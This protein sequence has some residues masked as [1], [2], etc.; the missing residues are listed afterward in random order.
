MCWPFTVI[1]NSSSD[2][3]NFVKSWTSASNFKS[4]SRS[5]Y[6]NFS[7]SRSEKIWKRSTYYHLF[8]VSEPFRYKNKQIK[9][10]EGLLSIE[11]ARLPFDIGFESLK[12]FNVLSEYNYSSTG[13]RLTTCFHQFSQFFSPIVLSWKRKQISYWSK[14]CLFSQFWT[15]EKINTIISFTSSNNQFYKSRTS[16][17]PI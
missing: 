9:Y 8:Q 2:P 14:K 4:F 10:G 6:T 7:H 3:Q 15:F 13:D 16:I 11:Q 5:L 12:P 1:I 17:F